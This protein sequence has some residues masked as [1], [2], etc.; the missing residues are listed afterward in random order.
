MTF[1]KSSSWP[2]FDDIA[3]TCTPR[4]SSTDL[5]QCHR[6]GP[7]VQIAIFVPCRRSLY[8]SSLRLPL[9]VFLGDQLLALSSMPK[10]A[11]ILRMPSAM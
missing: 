1:S 8:Q 3:T 4:S 2:N 10:K 9:G 7:P 5:V 11:Q 6:R